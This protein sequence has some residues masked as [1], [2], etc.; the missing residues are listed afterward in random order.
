ML[1]DIKNNK[2]QQQQKEKQ[3]ENE[4]EIFFERL[5]CLVFQ[6]FIQKYHTWQNNTF[7]CGIISTKKHDA[8]GYYLFLLHIYNNLK[9]WYKVALQ[10][11]T[12]DWYGSYGTQ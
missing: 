1:L 6:F 8:A 2:Q 9:L 4:K 3:T 5:Y 11:T 7:W 12:T 10:I